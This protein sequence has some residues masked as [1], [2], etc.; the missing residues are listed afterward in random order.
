KARGPQPGEPTAFP[1]RDHNGPSART[2][3]PRFSGPPSA[4]HTPIARQ[5][6]RTDY[7]KEPGGRDG[8]YRDRRF[9]NKAQGDPVAGSGSLPSLSKAVGG[10][11]VGK[12]MVPI[13]DAPAVT[14]TL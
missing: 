13:P 11:L 2:H 9:D 14:S 5:Y 6:A 12:E 1:E 10:E 3:F 7:E 4:D 8:R